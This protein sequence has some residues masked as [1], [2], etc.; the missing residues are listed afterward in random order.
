MHQL[1][2]CSQSH[3]GPNLVWAQEEYRRPCHITSASILCPVVHGP[4]QGQ[5]WLGG[6]LFTMGMWSSM[7]LCPLRFLDDLAYDR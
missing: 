3:E 4:M 7:S 1:S 5:K 6:W 2:H